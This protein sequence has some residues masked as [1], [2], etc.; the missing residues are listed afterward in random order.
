MGRSRSLADSVTQAKI[1]F[2]ATITMGPSPAISN[3]P[4]GWSITYDELGGV[5]LH[6]PDNES[7]SNYVQV[8]TAAKPGAAATITFGTRTTTS[9]IV[10]AWNVSGDP[11][12]EFVFVM[13]VDL[14][15]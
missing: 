12:D 4:P 7:I 10:R 5:T 6:H 13:V 2:A 8:A 11:V 14:R 3:P 9:I 15:T 1:I